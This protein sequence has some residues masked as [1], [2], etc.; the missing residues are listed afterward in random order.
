MDCGTDSQGFVSDQFRNCQTTVGGFC[1]TGLLDDLHVRRDAS[2][3][4]RFFVRF[5]DGQV[6]FH[7]H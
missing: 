4:T 5:A 6:L 2:K 1:D 3:L 7:T